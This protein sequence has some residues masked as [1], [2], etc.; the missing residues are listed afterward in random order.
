M[1]PPSPRTHVHI[2]TSIPLELRFSQSDCAYT[3]LITFFVFRSADFVPHESRSV[4][5]ERR[6][7]DDEAL[8]VELE[9]QDCPK[10]CEHELRLVFM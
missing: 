6:L 9:R 5:A 10:V 2:D 1:P 4:D 8:R 3:S 7:R